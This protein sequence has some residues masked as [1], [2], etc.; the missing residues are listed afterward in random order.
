M[1]VSL[2]RLLGKCLCVT[3]DFHVHALHPSRLFLIC[4]LRNGDF[5]ASLVVDAVLAIKYTDIRGQPR[6]PVNSIDVLK[7]HGR[8]QMEVCSSMAMLSTVWWD[9][10]VRLVIS[11]G[12]IT[13]VLKDTASYLWIIY[14]IFRWTIQH[15]HFCSLVKSRDK[16]NGTS[17]C[18]FLCN[19]IAYD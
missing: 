17:C 9:P 11:L 4:W 8:S 15:V 3:L 14:S 10:R 1:R 2:V 16:G 18:R 12:H 6:Y 5:F 19:V 7:A 13:R